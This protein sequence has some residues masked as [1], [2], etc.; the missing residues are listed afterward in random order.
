[1]QIASKFEAKKVASLK[2][3]GVVG[4]EI[5]ILLRML[6]IVGVR[7]AKSDAEHREVLLDMVEAVS[8]HSG[9][10]TRRV[11]RAASFSKLQFSLNERFVGGHFFKRSVFIDSD[12]WRTS[13]GIQV[14]LRIGPSP[15]AGRFDTA[16]IEI[17][18]AHEKEQ[19]ELRGLLVERLCSVANLDWDELPFNP[20]LEVSDG[21]S[22]ECPQRMAIDERLLVEFLV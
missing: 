1:M 3:I 4:I 22:R 13:S 6:A 21:E 11:R 9:L 17:C 5:P 15:N 14:N 2:F 19:E 8:G 18:F 10:W 16:T 12:T 20:A 7:F